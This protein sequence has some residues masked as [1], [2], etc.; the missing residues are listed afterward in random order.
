MRM[1]NK[2]K[3]HLANYARFFGVYFVVATF[4]EIWQQNVG[5]EHYWLIECGS[6]TI[7]VLVTAWFGWRAYTGMER[8]GDFYSDD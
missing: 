1:P 5:I 2:L 3:N 8:D 6:I 4:I 7:L